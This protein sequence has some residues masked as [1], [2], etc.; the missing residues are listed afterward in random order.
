M[1]TT[2]T[3]YLNNNIVLILC[4]KNITIFEFEMQT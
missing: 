4:N 1:E 2:T 3:F